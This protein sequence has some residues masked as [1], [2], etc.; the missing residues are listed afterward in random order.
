MITCRRSDQSPVGADVL[1][2]DPASV[3]ACQQGH[4]VGDVLRLPQAT[5]RCDLGEPLLLLFPFAL[6]KQLWVSWA[7][8]HL[9]H[10]DP[11]GAEYFGEHM[12]ELLDGRGVAR[13][14][15]RC[16][17]RAEFLNMPNMRWLWNGSCLDYKNPEARNDD[18]LSLFPHTSPV[19]GSAP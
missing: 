12:A 13:W 17:G 5:Q 14:Q 2:S 19:I 9:I 4:H 15:T 7:R 1:P 16:P 10:R 6:A 18:E 8:R 3:V 11:P